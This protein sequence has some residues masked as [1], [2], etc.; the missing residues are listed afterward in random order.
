MFKVLKPVAWNVVGHTFHQHVFGNLCNKG[1]SGTSE[2]WITIRMMARPSLKPPKIKR[3]ALNVT[4]KCSVTPT[5]SVIEASHLRDDVAH[6][7]A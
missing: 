2:A 3:T 5:P 7:A 1:V 6:L 4:R